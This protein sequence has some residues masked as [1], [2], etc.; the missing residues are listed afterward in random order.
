MQAEGLSDKIIASVLGEKPSKSSTS[1]TTPPR[2]GV[3]PGFHWSP[4]PSGEQL[5][6][7]IWARKKPLIES[8]K[9]EEAIDISKHIELF[10]KK[11]EGSKTPQKKVKSGAETKEMAKLMDLNRANNVVITLKAFNNFSHIKLAQVIKF[12][13]PFEN[14]NGDRA[15]FMKDLL[16]AMAEIKAIKNYKGKDDRL[17]V[18]VER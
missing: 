15:L 17:L 14:I 7:S 1:S 18:P 12:I 8:E 2:R 9:P 11:P 16:P 3:K 4:L 10:Q 5:Q 6:N 13:D